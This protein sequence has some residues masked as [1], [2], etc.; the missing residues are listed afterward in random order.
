MSESLSGK[1]AAVTGGTRGIGRAIV[2]RF[3][4]EGA[5][6]AFCG[7]TKKGVDRAVKELTERYGESV[8]G[9]AADVSKLDQVRNFF[10]SV[11]ER[12]GRLDILVN[13]AGLG[14][15]ASVENLQPEDWERM[16]G[17]NLTGVY[18]CSH[19]ALPLMKRSGGG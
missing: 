15:F 9:E 1:V 7:A 16:I 12:S 4:H 10:R 19:E 11:E 13:N 8:T 18:Y 5:H 3:L 14:I 6:V 2:E 17:V